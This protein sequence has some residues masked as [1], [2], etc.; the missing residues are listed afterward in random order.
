MEESFDFDDFISPLGKRYCLNPEASLLLAMT[1]IEATR[2]ALNECNP[3]NQAVSISWL[4]ERAKDRSGSPRC[5]VRA[6]WKEK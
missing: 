1:Q 3:V 6:N 2:L 5:V 4:L